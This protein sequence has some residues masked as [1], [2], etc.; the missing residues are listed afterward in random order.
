M[1]RI[2]PLSIAI[3]G[4]ACATISSA[5]TASSAQAS[6]ITNNLRVDI[7]SGALANQSF[8]GSFTYN[9]AALTDPSIQITNPDGNQIINPTNGLLNL[10]FNFLGTT[11]SQNSD[12]GFPDYPQLNFQAGLFKG[13]DY[14]VESVANPATIAAFGTGYIQ[15]SGLTFFQTFDGSPFN[16]ATNVLDE[17]TVTYGVQAVPAPALLPGLIGLGVGVLRKRRAEAKEQL[18]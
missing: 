1:F 10:S 13:L 15:S 12:S 17:G 6:T 4:A 16:S 7:T 18:V 9:D 14:L 5:V 3:A 11:Y 2:K 8:F